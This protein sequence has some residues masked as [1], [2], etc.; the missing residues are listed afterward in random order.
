[1]KKLITL[2]LAF[3]LTIAAYAQK[4]KEYVFTVKNAV[5]NNTHENITGRYISIKIIANTSATITYKGYDPEVYEIKEDTPL[6]S[7]DLSFDAKLDG[8][9]YSF[10]FYQSKG[11]KYFG[12]IK[13]QQLKTDITLILKLQK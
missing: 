8:Y 4:N 5:E 3:T 1:M 13:C 7:K 10:V 6:F 12:E 11:D 9:W 2:A